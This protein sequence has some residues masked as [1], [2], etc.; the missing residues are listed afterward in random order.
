MAHLA[1]ESFPPRHLPSD[2][3]L[4]VLSFIPPHCIYCGYIFG[5]GA[6]VYPDL[7]PYFE[8]T[9][10]ICPCTFRHLNWDIQV[11]LNRQLAY[12]KKRVVLLRLKALHD[13]I[14]LSTR[15]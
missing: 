12:H 1:L 2:I 9:S 11:E 5:A 15:P 7:D 3:I 6:P 14:P 8:R 4:L 10:H 13:L